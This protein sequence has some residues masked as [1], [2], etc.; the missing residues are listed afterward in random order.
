M[1]AFGEMAA[2][3]TLEGARIIL[4]WI[5]RERKH[6]FSKRECWWGVHGRALFEMADDLDRPLQL[7]CDHHI[8]RPVPGE[9][10]ADDGKR[11]GRKASARFEVNPQ[12]AVQNV[13]KVH[14]W[15]APAGEDNSGRSGPSD[16]SGL[17]ESETIEV[18][19]V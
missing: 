19:R 18:W 5:E 12:I 15:R 2:N 10:D 6:A 16:G 1:A 17:D 4:G 9:D 8:I 11:R 13:H 14:N 7:L 3:P